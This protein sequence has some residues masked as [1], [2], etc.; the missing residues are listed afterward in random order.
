MFLIRIILTFS[1][2]IDIRKHKKMID[3]SIN[4]ITIRNQTQIIHSK[5][6]MNFNKKGT[7]PYPFIYFSSS[8]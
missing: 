5:T 8:C 7:T 6:Q 1:I 4:Q 3:I 2:C